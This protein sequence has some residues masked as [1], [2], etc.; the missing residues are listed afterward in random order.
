[1][2]YIL[3]S[4]SDTDRSY[5]H[6]LYLIALISPSTSLHGLRQQSLCRWLPVSIG[7]LEDSVRSVRA[8]SRPTNLHLVVIGT[9][10]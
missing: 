10:D 4:A 3:V 7:D 8:Q 5:S 2:E 6:F 1:M 9:N